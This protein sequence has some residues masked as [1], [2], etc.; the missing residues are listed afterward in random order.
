MTYTVSG[1]R[2]VVLLPL[3]GAVLGLAA[4]LAGAAPLLPVTSPPVIN[5]GDTGPAFDPAATQGQWFQSV[6]G[7]NGNAPIL[8][9]KVESR[10]FEFDDNLPGFGGGSAGANAIVGKILSNSLTYDGAGLVTGFTIHATIT[11]DTPGSGSYDP[12]ANS[13]GETSLASPVAGPLL[14]AKLTVEFADDGVQGNFPAS[15]TP[16][17]GPESNVYA[18]GYDQL[19]WYSYTPTGGFQVPTWD[20]G[21]IAVGQSVSRDL[22]FGLYTAVDQSV[23]QY[24][25]DANDV[26]LNASTDLKI[27]DYFETAGYNGIA[28]D[29][30]SPYPSTALRGGDVSVFANVPEPASL[31]LLLTGLGGLMARG[32]RRKF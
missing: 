27:G 6:S 20:F 18:K 28:I 23:I 1:C 17:Y 25:I 19:A 8:G 2:S 11:N 21:D 31:A 5:A 29:D 13:H 7:F 9:S 12:G 15:G 3:V 16:Y 22:S 26:F 32:R 30:G 4:P 10:G 14:G 24:L